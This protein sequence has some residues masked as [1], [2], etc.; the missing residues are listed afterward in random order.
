MKAT[1]RIGGLF[2]ATMI[3]AGLLAGFLGLSVIGSTPAAAA[4]VCDWNVYPAGENPLQTAINNA[5]SG[6]TICVFGGVYSETVRVPVG[7]T[8]LTLIAAPGESPVID[9][10]KNLPGGMLADRFRALVELNGSGTTFDGFEVRYSS[11]GGID[12]TANDVVVRNNSVHDNWS[13]GINARSSGP[14]SGIQIENNQVYNNVRR[15]QQMPVIY[16]GLRGA[17]NGVADWVFD[18]AT[19]WDTPFWT[20]ANADLPEQWVNSI[21]MTFNDDGATSRVYV[22][23]S[24]SGRVGYIGAEYSSTGQQFSYSG[25]DIL[26]HE[27]ATNQWTLYFD[28]EPN[29]IPQD[30][31]IDAFQIESA[32]PISESWPCDTCA[33]ILLSFTAT[34]SISIT[35]GVMTPTI[36]QTVIGPSDLVYFRPTAM[37]ATR[38]S[39]GYYTLYKRATDLV[40]LPEGANIDALD[41][42]PDGRL[43]ISL[44]GDNVLANPD[45]STVN[46]ERENLVAFDEATGYWSLFF[47]GDQIAY[48]PF[49]AEDLTAAWVDNDGNIYISGDPVGGS[50]LT[51]ID[52]RNSTARDNHIFNNFGEG[53]VV[54]RGSDGALAE[55]NVLYDNLHAN[56]YLNSTTNATIRG[57]FVYCTDDQTFWSKSSRSTYKPGPGIQIR[58]EIM[59][60]ESGRPL[61]S[62]YVIVNNIVYGCGTNFG[63]AT[64]RPGGGLNNSLVANNTFA[65]ARSDDPGNSDNVNFNFNNGTSVSGSAF[66]NNLL[67]QSPSLSN[68][69]RFQA[70]GDLS[71]F[72]IAHNL[73]SP[74]PNSWPSQW[75][76]NEPGRIVVADPHLANADLGNQNPPL[77]VMGTSPNPADFQLTYNSSAL[78]A[79]QM[80]AEVADDFFA[81]LRAGNGAPDIGAHELPHI[82]RIIVTQTTAPAGSVQ[83]FDFTAG[84]SPAGFSLDDGEQHDSGVLEAGTYALSVA[85]VEG[86]T[87]TAACS[88][89]SPIESILLGPNETVICAFISVRK[90]QITLNH[91]VDPTGDTTLFDFTLSP[92]E[93]FQMGSESRA[94]V[95][96]PGAYSLTATAPPGWQQE[97]ACNNGDAP[98]ALALDAGESVMCTFTHRRLGRIIVS[99]LTNPPNTPGTF[100]FITSYAPGGFGLSHGQSHE[101][102]FLTPYAQYSVVETL[103]AGW[104]QLSAVCDDGSSPDAIDLAAGE[105]V[106]CTFTNA[107]LSLGLVVEPTPGAVTTPGGDVEFAVRVLNDGD[108]PVGAISLI[109]SI[110]GDVTD[111]NNPALAGTNCELPQSLAAGEDYTCAFTAYIAGAGGTV[112]NSTLT[113]SGMG[114]NSTPVSTVAETAVTINI[115]PPGRIIVTKQTDPPDA[116]GVFQFT[117]SYGDFSLSNGQNHDSGLLLS[118]VIYSVAEMP[119][120]GWVISSATCTGDD[121]GT[122]PAAIMLDPGEV[123]TCTFV[124]SRTTSGPLATFYLTTPKKGSIQGLAYSPGDILAYDN[125]VATWSIYFDASNVGLTKAL[126]DFTL[127]DDGSILL[128]IGAKV[129]LR[130]TNNNFITVM[131]QDIVRFVPAGLGA[132]TAGY[133]EMVFD[134]SDVALSTAGEKIDALA[135]RPDGTL[136]ISTAGVATVK[137]SGGVNIKAQDEDLLAFTFA[138]SGE[139]TTGTWDANRAFDGSTLQ[140]MAVEDV[141]AAWRHPDSGYL[142]LTVTNNFTIKGIKGNNR[143]ILSVSPTGDVT[144]YWDASTAGFKAAID[145]LHIRFAP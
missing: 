18:P 115:P 100:D 26:F 91:V 103:P 113:A 83:Q 137:N 102:E 75:P 17:G 7:K 123:V 73:Y 46:A 129:K 19:Y 98:G 53:L 37:D 82:G 125:A 58:D 96:E 29:G 4:P 111:V 14:I 59:A 81:L 76:G 99:V 117:A 94:F 47:D 57:N 70:T 44:S 140:G 2:F 107:R 13:T 65:H 133:F 124:N 106:V 31:V 52:T 60:N 109:D 28:G 77:P 78:D 22:G 51:L 139:T 135:I 34:V 116:S 67:I 122:D 127:L 68:N 69:I 50:A 120:A 40:G 84:F 92:D 89:G 138:S 54:D 118:G 93:T 141:T 45:G 134:G 55:G 74:G 130:D 41:R 16:R 121:D 114:S 43:L 105:V 143:T 20:G 56:L 142:Y 24:R 38:I 33:P 25:A 95:I 72:T 30:S 132:A 27:P 126:S 9:G 64:Q 36:T 61:S 21:A 136:L 23:S 48:N 104:V 131:P 35:E 108:V 15:A 49:Q 39:S 80:L 6:Q 8:S 10:Q 110:Y 71:N 32:A 63:V 88:D 3:A 79:G 11:A 85:P 145:G 101:S 62:G 97:A 87:T 112:H 119:S 90:A 144:D 128:A 42:A 86:W 66:V 12:I 1:T 5:A